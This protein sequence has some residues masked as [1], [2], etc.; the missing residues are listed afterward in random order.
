VE[1]DLI[2]MT[3]GLQGFL[4]TVVAAGVV[5][6]GL[7]FVRPALTNPPV[8]AEIQAPDDVKAV[9]RSS[10]Y[11]C[12]SNETKLPWFDEV[13]PAYWLVTHDV[14]EAR[15]HLNFSE[16]GKL[17]AAE[18]KGKLFEAVNMIQMGEMPLPRYVMVHPGSVVSAE[19]LAVL[20]SYLTAP[21]DDAKIAEAAAKAV[22]DAA[23]ADAQYAEWVHGGATPIQVLPEFNGVGFL[24]DYKNWKAI[25][26]TDRFDNHTMREILGND[27]AVKAIAD[28]HI[29][30]WPDGTSF[31]KVAW[32]E[33]Q[34]DAQGVVKT[35]AF[36]QVEL[37]IKD[38]RKYSASEGWGW[39]RWRGVDLKPY[40]KD[41][42]FQ[43]ECLSCHAP[44]AKND[45]V[46]TMPFRGQIGGGQ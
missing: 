30:P 39:G 45:Q 22:T 7:Q 33:A 38:S 5:F 24:P 42:K 8:M 29:N 20:R 40:G 13:V 28:G 23:A 18:Q 6:V 19:G 4:G 14:K 17:P 2:L 44:V 41:A 43:N 46:Y 37:M 25:S 32:Q 27:V 21:P 12:H 31:A 36:I 34:P 11:S 3:R 1:E 35:G 10:C 16:I 15:E 9:L 26:S